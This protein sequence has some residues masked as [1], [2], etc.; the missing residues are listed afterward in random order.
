ML[1]Q[2]ALSLVSCVEMRRMNCQALQ[3][4]QAFVLPNLLS[5]VVL[6]HTHFAII[7][8]HVIHANFI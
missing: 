6:S 5:V 7:H 2:E 1:M 8:P 4:I 3:I